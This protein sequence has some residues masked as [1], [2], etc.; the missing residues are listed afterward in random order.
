VGDGEPKG[1]FDYEIEGFKGGTLRTRLEGELE[2]VTK[3]TKELVLKAVKQKGTSVHKWL[4]DV[5]KAA[6]QK[7]LKG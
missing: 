2:G 3:E 4:D 7:D 5:V 6:A 1:N